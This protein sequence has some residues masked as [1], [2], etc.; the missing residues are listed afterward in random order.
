MI[1]NS[2]GR[3]GARMSKMINNQVLTMR[4]DSPL[5]GIRTWEGKIP[6]SRIV[7]LEVERYPLHSLPAHRHLEGVRGEAKEQMRRSH[8]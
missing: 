6:L 4:K 8:H 3:S 1:E 5:K 7:S 2:G